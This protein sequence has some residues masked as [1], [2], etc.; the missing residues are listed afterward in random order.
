MYGFW[1]FSFEHYNG[2]LGSFSTNNRDI[3]VQL[4]RKFLTMSSLDDLHFRMPSTFQDVFQP[5][6]SDIQ[7]IEYDAELVRT[8]S[9]ALSF[10]LASSGP[11]TRSKHVWTDLSMVEL[12]DRYRL[13]AFDPDDLGLLKGTYSALYPDINLTACHVNATFKKYQS[14]C[15]AGEGLSS[16]MESRLYKHA[17]IMATWAGEE[18][19]TALSGCKPGRVKFYFEHSLQLRNDY[20]THFFAS[21]QWF[22]E[23]DIDTH[24]R[25]PL[26]VYYAKVFKQPGPASFIPV[27]RIQSRFIAV[28]DKHQNI[29]ILVVFPL[30]KKT[31][32]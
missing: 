27:Q 22:K 30:L 15:V 16:G 4:M 28:H 31:Y 3:E 26:S 2:V 10:A 20:R 13:C 18:G 17:R 14:V 5:L 24:F 9:Q 11:L 21:V 19:E 6:C 29:D 8:P 12:P 25:N 23:Y 7:E 32:L 1:L